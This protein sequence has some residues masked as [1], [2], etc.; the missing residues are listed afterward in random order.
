M[1]L[2]RKFALTVLSLLCAVLA[3]GGTL[4]LHRNFAAA[5][6]AAE[7]QCTAAHLRSRLALED[8]IAACRHP[9]GI[10]AATGRYALELRAA[11]QQKDL[12]VLLTAGG[13]NVWSNAPAALPYAEQQAAVA[14]GADRLHYTR[15]GDTW[16]LLLASPLQSSLPDLWL[17]S[18][19]D[20][21]ETFAE[22]ERQLHQQLAVQAAA[23]ALAGLAALLAARRLTGPLRR[24]EEASRGIA[25][26]DYARRVPVRGRDEVAALGESFN[27]MAAAVQDHA[28]ALEAEAARQTRFVA[29]FTHEMKTP[30][31][32]ILG[33][34]DLL[35]SGEQPHEVRMLEAGHIYHE[36]ARLE[37]LSHELL[38][39]L[40]LR[41]GEAPA[42]GP[43]AVGPLFAAAAGCL[44]PALQHVQVQ[45][46][47][48]A[49]A[50][51]WGSRTLL[52]ALLRNLVLNAAA[53]IPANGTVRLSCTPCPSGNGW[54]LA[55]TDEGHGIP[56]ADL[57][58]VQEAFYRVDK[59]RA[60]AAGQGGNGLGLTLCAEI[61]AAHGSA[62]HIESEPDKGTTVWLD[63]PQEGVPV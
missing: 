41:Q 44:P 9:A 43:V 48:P 18:G 25:G 30:M 52:E 36:A 12:L 31:T 16:Y 40:G 19:Y 8:G 7:Q 42:M 62:L 17:V 15:C 51:A 2:A 10:A 63:L 35:R 28:A 49:G 53:A 60:R 37:A 24:L 61:A 20:V 13:M 11:G 21:S 47:A 23:L 55:V 58:H 22:H 4:T 27:A 33:H 5:L 14:A 1:S 59:S 3:L 38:A 56:P 45:A 57:P 26:G 54:R 34:A 39:L 29:A 32:A 50:Q 46:D 6:S